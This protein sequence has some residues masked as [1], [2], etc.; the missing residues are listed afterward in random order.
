[1]ADHERVNPDSDTEKAE[2]DRQI[3]EQALEHGEQDQQGIS[4]HP[5]AEEQR[6][7]ADLP[8]RGEAKQPD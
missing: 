8:P 3:V 7:Q 6:E 1:M 4:N 2:G 5:A